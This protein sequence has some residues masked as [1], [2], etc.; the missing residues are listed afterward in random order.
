MYRLFYISRSQKTLDK[1]EQ[2][3]LAL[4]EKPLLFKEK[5]PEE[6]VENYIKFYRTQAHDSVIF[7]HPKLKDLV[8]QQMGI[9]DIIPKEHPELKA[10]ANKI[11]DLGIKPLPDKMIDLDKFLATRLLKNPNRIINEDTNRILKNAIFRYRS[12][13]SNVVFL[14]QDLD[15]Y[16][17]LNWLA[18]LKEPEKWYTGSRLCK[19]LRVDATSP[20]IAASRELLQEARDRAMDADLPTHQVRRFTVGQIGIAHYINDEGIEAELITGP[21]VRFRAQEMRTRSERPR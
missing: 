15:S 2:A 19:T 13:S 14:H 3:V 6:E 17:A 9:P 21:M 7:I 11:I 1:V 18:P 10:R 5:F 20:N 4:L 16:L 12:G 8:L